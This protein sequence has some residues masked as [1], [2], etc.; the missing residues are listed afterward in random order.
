MVGKK[1]FSIFEILIGFLL[2]A[3]IWFNGRENAVNALGFEINLKNGLMIAGFFYLIRSIVQYVAESAEATSMNFMKKSVLFFEMTTGIV[4]MITCFCDGKDTPI[5]KAL[6]TEITMYHGLVVLG[7]FF[8]CK[9]VL[10]LA[11][12]QVSEV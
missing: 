12:D 2:F 6:N 1:I 7:V 8:A 11:F 5:E 9:A 10:Q 3:C 4:M